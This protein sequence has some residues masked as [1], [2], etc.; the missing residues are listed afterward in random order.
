VSDV[1]VID[2]HLQLKLL[3]DPRRLHL[4]RL[5]MAEPA[6]LTSLG[7]RVGRHP[8]WVRHHLQRLEQAGLVE[9]HVQ[10]GRERLYRAT[11]RALLVQTM[12]LPDGPHD[13]TVVFSGSHDLAIELLRDSLGDAADLLLLCNGSLDGLVTLRQGLSHVAGCHLFDPSLGAYN[14]PFIQH[15]FPDR[16]MCLITLA[17]RVQGLLLTKGNPRRIHDLSDLARPGVAFVNRNP[18]SGTRLWLDAALGSLSILPSQIHGYSRIAPTHTDVALAVRHGKA[19]VGL[20][21]QAAAL[22][23]ELDFVPLFQERYQLAIPEEQMARPA[24]QAVMNHLGSGPFR[25]AMLELGGYD[26][27]QTGD[28][29]PCAVGVFS[30]KPDIHISHGGLQ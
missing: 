25:R 5:L 11:A 22:R 20:G 2:S 21:L 27:S 12:V 13:R 17:E 10:R 7:A 26:T 24:I 29:I 23:H 19:D 28:R 8:A 18:G 9:L 30:T 14:S 6:S 4:L 16:P 15:L 1:A 3:S